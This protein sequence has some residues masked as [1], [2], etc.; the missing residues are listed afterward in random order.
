MRI[1]TVGKNKECV[2]LEFN[3]EDD[4][5]RAFNEVLSSKGKLGIIT[6]GSGM[7]HQ[8]YANYGYSNDMTEILHVLKR[9][10]F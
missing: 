9:E 8:I 7:R 10:K 4:A 5:D 6:D 1:Y 2:T 3:S